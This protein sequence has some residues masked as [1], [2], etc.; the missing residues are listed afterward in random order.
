MVKSDLGAGADQ[1]SLRSGSG[2]VAELLA[3]MKSDFV[4]GAACCEASTSLILPP[5]VELLS[6]IAYPMCRVYLTSHL[7][8]S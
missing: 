8:T 1:L 4:G 5:Q 3:L 2:D 7:Y 6:L